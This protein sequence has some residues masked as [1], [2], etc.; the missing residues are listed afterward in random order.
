[1]Y[2]EWKEMEFP[3]EMQDEVRENERIMGGEGWQEKSI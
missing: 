1:M 2:R 3:K